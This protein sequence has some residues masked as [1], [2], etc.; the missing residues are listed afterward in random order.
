MVLVV[1]HAFLPYTVTWPG[2]ELSIQ[3]EVYRKPYKL[4]LSLQEVTVLPACLRLNGGWSLYLE[5]NLQHPHPSD[6]GC[7][8]Q[9]WA[10][11]CVYRWFLPISVC[12]CTNVC[13]FKSVSLYVRLSFANV[14]GLS[15]TEAPRFAAAHQVNS[16]CPSWPPPIQPLPKFDLSLP[17]RQAS[18]YH[19]YFS[20]TRGCTSNGL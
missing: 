17:H 12:E 10:H 7:S 8:P 15:W 13:S 19:H 5:M 16:C 3:S 6:V 14:K 18:I 2:L 9:C 1:F 20:P 4:E 11:P